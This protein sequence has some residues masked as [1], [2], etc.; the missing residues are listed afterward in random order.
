MH[1]HRRRVI[2]Y[3]GGGAAKIIILNN[4]KKNTKLNENKIYLF[5][6]I[7]PSVY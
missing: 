6:T 5:S 7:I 3:I 1:V 4:N 2:K